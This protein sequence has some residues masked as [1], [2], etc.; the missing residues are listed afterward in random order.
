MTENVLFAALLPS[1]SIQYHHEYMEVLIQ[2]KK[3]KYA[4]TQ[5]IVSKHDYWMMNSEI[6]IILRK[7]N[8]P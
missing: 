2:N 7:A 8:Y 6:I 3:D 1:L 5:L 4:W